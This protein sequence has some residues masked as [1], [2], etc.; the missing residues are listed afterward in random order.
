VFVFGGADAA[1]EEADVDAFVGHGF[2]VFVF[3][4]EGDG[5]EDEGGG[6]DDVEDFFVEVQHCDFAAAAAGCP[7][8]GD[9]EF[10]RVGC[11]RC[12]AHR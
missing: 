1:V 6:G 4:V 9:G 5:P 3:G 8:Q 10:R 11:G 12:C 7:V 2:D